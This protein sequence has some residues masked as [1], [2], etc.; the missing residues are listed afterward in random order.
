MW[1]PIQQNFLVEDEN[2]LHNIPYMGDE[3]LEKDGTFIEELIKNYD[4]RYHGDKDGAF[5]DDTMFVELVHAL[6]TYQ[7][8]TPN[9]SETETKISNDEPSTSKAAEKEDKKPTTGMELDEMNGESA[10]DK[11]PFPCH[12]IFKAISTNYP[13]KG[14]ADELREK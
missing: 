13:D 5:I 4:G 10:L 3:F 6:M 11:K 7:V 2:E 14:T 1:A 8:P 9:S 12:E